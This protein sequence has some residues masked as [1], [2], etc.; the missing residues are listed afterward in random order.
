ML[1]SM[2]DMEEGGNIPG[3][4]AYGRIK[5]L[6]RLMEWYITAQ[7]FGWRLFIASGKYDGKRRGFRYRF[8]RQNVA[9]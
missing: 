9:A 1:L 8:W 4:F 2:I 5:S 3:G 7:I 6:P